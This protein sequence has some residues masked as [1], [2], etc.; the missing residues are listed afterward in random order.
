M[1]GANAVAFLDRVEADEAF[2]R[3]IEAL[4]SDPAAAHA[5]VVEAGYDATPEEIKMAFVAR[6]GSELSPEQLEALAGGIDG[7]DIGIGVGIGAGVILIG[8]LAGLAAALV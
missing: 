3:K 7:T 1:S 6:Y 2:A 4:K 5:A 8:A